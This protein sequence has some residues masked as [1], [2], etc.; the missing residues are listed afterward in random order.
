MKHENNTTKR[1]TKNTNMKFSLYKHKEV[2]YTYYG[3]NIVT[4]LVRDSI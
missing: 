3:F 4:F 2:D 1:K